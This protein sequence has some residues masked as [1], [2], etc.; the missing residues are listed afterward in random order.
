MIL[1][2]YI[3]LSSIH[4]PCEK[5]KRRETSSDLGATTNCAGKQAKLYL[6][7]VVVRENLSCT[8]KFWYCIFP[9]SPQPQNHKP[10]GL[11]HY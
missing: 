9:S 11:H 1:L 5:K 7:L 8:E 10:F 3:L 2:Y 6:S 4:H